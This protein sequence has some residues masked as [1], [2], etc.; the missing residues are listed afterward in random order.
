MN[1][2][3]KS[4]VFDGKRYN[5]FDWSSSK[6]DAEWEKKQLKKEGKMVRLTVP[7]SKEGY[8]VWVR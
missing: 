5:L 1:N 3:A 4:R 6:K 7:P 2:Q 8:F